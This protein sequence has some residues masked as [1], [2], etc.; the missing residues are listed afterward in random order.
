MKPPPDLHPIV[1]S[2]AELAYRA[3]DRAYADVL[4]LQRAVNEF[5]QNAGGD[6]ADESLNHVRQAWLDSRPS[7]GRTEAF[8]FYEGP[9]DFGKR[10]DGTQGPEPLIN[11]WPLNEAYIDY[12]RGNPGAGIIN[13]P[14][15]PITRAALTQR[16][17]RDDEVDVTTGF[18]AIEFLLWGQDFNADGPG[19]RPARDFVGGGAAARRRE[20]LKVVTDLLADNLEFVRDE[21]APGRS[22][23]Y[24]AGLVAMDTRESVAHILTGIATLAGFEVAAERLATPLDSGAQEDEH[25]CFSDTTDADILANVSGIADVYMGR[26]QG[27]QGIALASAVAAASPDINDRIT[28]QLA[29]SLRLAKALDHPFDRTLATP[30]GSPQRARVEALVTSLQTLARLFKI[31]GQ[32]LGVNIVVTVEIEH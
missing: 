17:A 19:N 7:Y 12:V 10:P 20:Y 28:E 4:S 14:G 5:V 6:D 15:V 8:R 18:H 13:D 25:S 24:R 2:Y 21:W 32:L 31:G 11:A 22:D 16:N 1:E 26:S 30:S 23:N 27:Y 3:Y 9:I 29:T